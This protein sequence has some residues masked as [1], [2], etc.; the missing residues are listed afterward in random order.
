M[1][2]RLFSCALIILNCM[3]YSQGQTSRWKRSKRVQPLMGCEKKLAGGLLA[4]INVNVS[5]LCVCF[6][7]PGSFLEADGTT[8]VW[9]ADELKAGYPGSFMEDCG[10]RLPG[11]GEP[12]MG[13]EGGVLSGRCPQS[14]SLILSEWALGY[15]ATFSAVLPQEDPLKRPLRGWEVETVEDLSDFWGQLQDDTGVKG[16]ESEGHR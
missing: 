16:T 10:V 12:Y 3:D 7:L 6:H 14:Q 1:Q 2:F 13:R 11:A 9:R 15:T 4:I 8:P 5:S